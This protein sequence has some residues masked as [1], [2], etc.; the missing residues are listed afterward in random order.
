MRRLRAWF[1][2]KVTWIPRPVKKILILI[3]GGTILL[4]GI[5]MMIAPGPAF[6]VI[7]LGLAVLAIEFAFARRWL[8]QLKK[9]ALA[10]KDRIQGNNKAK[11]NAT[12][13]TTEGSSDPGSAD[14]MARGSAAA[15]AASG[16]NPHSGG[17]PSGLP[18]APRT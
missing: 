14:N 11:L 15:S 10:A 9:T 17:N 16:C 7:P 5:V 12:G 18:G 3:I 1:R 4:I 13:K 6:I 2:R 8:K